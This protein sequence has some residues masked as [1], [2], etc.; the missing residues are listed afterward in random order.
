MTG[1]NGPKRLSARV[2]CSTEPLLAIYSYTIVLFHLFIPLSFLD[3]ALVFAHNT[4]HVV[5]NLI[6]S[7]T[8]LLLIILYALFFH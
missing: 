4:S 1:M 6:Y 2:Q 5:N 7:S 3:D 8:S